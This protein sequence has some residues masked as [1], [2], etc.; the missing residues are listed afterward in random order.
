MGYET[1][2]IPNLQGVLQDKADIKAAIAAK[3]VAVPDA[4]KLGDLPAL[5]Q[6][7][8]TGGGGVEL[9][10]LVNPAAA[11]DIVSGKEAIDG[12][13][14]K[15]TGTY[16]PPTLSDLLPALSNAATAADIASGKQA[17]NAAGEVVTGTAGKGLLLYQTYNGRI[18]KNESAT[19]SI[20][21]EKIAMHSA[22]WCNGIHGLNFS[23]SGSVMEAWY[24]DTDIIEVSVLYNN[25]TYTVVLRNRANYDINFG[26]TNFGRGPLFIY[27]G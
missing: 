19:F 3:G 8:E 9:P 10:A 4:A 22:F 12:N 13:G 15:L 2:L 14:N 20:Q 26:F 27:K 16:T 24:V 17:I 11:T 7:I 21:A 18:P 23:Y 25:G 5:V 6:Q 1:D